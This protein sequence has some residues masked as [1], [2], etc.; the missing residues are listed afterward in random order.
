VKSEKRGG[1]ER[2][3][4]TEEEEEEKSMKEMGIKGRSIRIGRRMQ[5]LKKKRMRY[6]ME[7]EKRIRKHEGE[8]KK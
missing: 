7:G 6:E 1:E 5:N 4:K 2:K 8:E 3:E